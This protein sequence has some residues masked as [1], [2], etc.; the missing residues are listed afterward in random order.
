MKRI[1]KGDEVIV[2]AGRSKGQRGTVLKVLKDDRLLVE[3]VN[4]IKKHVKPNPN[5]NEPGGIKEMEGP[6]HVSNVMLFNPDSGKG[7]RVGFK[8]LDDGRKVRV[9]RSS[10]ETV[11]A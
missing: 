8:V 7:D 2:I 10:G 6:I 4:M 5:L 9:F 11:D 1:R 3:N